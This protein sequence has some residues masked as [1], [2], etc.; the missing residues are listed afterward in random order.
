MRR[1]FLDANVFI[2]L[3]K[4]RSI[5]DTG[6][7][8]HLK[9]IYPHVYVSVLTIHIAFYV[10]K[11]KSGSRMHKKVLK[12]IKYVNILPLRSEIINLAMSLSFPDFEDMLQYLSAIGICEYILTRDKKDFDKLQKIFPSEITV[13]KSVS[14]V[15][16]K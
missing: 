8:E 16:E 10:L 6:I 11:I 14:D 9:D 13:V 5:G 7:R 3:L 15:L 1:V 4:D 2:D 12:L